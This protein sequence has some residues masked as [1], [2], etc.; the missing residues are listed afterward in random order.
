MQFKG[1][2]SFWVFSLGFGLTLLV[3]A[4][5]TTTLA[6]TLYGV[7]HIGFISGFLNTVHMMGAGLWSYLGGVIFDET[8]NY[9]LAFVLSAA[10]AALALVCTLLI[11]E[12]GTYHRVTG[13]VQYEP[14][15]LLCR[16]TQEN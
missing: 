4:P 10:L 5:L 7:T 2:A 15:R 6:A 11:R 1:S 13:H 14:Q 9:D 16:A 3:T 12:S 8:G